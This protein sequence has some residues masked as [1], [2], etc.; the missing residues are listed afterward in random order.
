MAKK[1]KQKATQRESVAAICGRLR[2]A[3]VKSIPTSWLDPMLSGPAAVI[4]LPPYDCEDIERLLE[5]VRA[6][7]RAAL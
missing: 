2:V 1:P 7:V 3:A 6:R 4:G 5:A